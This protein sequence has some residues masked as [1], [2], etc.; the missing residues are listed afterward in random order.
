M[1]ADAITQGAPSGI[2]LPLGIIADD[3]TGALDA[4]GP[5]ARRGWPVRVLLHPP[6]ATPAQPCIVAACSDSRVLPAAEAATC[7]V[8]LA[9]DLGAATLY[10]KIDSLLRGPLGAEVAALVYERRPAFTIVAPA[11]PAQ[12]RITLA[13]VQYARGHRVDRHTTAD[14][15]TPA[16]TA[17]V[18]ALLAT[19][20]IVAGHLP[21]ATVR[22]GADAIR[23]ALLAAR[24]DGRAVVGDAE[25]Q[26]DLDLLAAA[27]VTLAG[28]VLWCGSAG[29][30]HALS[31]TLPSRPRP[32]LPPA[33]R[34]LVICGSLHPTSIEQCAS[35]AA[36]DRVEAIRIDLAERLDA[37]AVA[38]RVARALIRFDCVL[39][40][41][42]GTNGVAR[43]EERRAALAALEGLAT[44][45]RASTSLGFV[46][47]GGE[48]AAAVCRGLRFDHLD[49]VDLVQDGIPCA[50]G[51]GGPCGGAP[52]I[53]K[54]GAFGDSMALVA[55][56]RYLLAGK[57]PI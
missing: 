53:T 44:R 9:R 41:L 31:A 38:S 46:L 47:T 50:I 23:V 40:T 8:A 12:G 1:F 3:L 34:V 35:L 25:E 17:D 24:S 54:A 6:Y 43:H 13:G 19:A 29:L 37:A 48:T 39:V 7:V 2:R 10:K 18:R 16:A 22:A 56:V 5:F 49:V 33:E 52:L 57:G 32:A 14:P 20:G 51:Q 55:A 4:A 15:F 27:G 30:A 45:V 42:A 28:D 26:S 11:F 36:S 21:L